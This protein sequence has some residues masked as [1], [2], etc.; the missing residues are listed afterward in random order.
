MSFTTE[1]RFV[2]EYQGG[3]TFQ[4]SGD[5]YVWVFVIDRLVMDLGGLHEVATGEFTLS[6]AAGTQGVATITREGP[7]GS[8]LTLD[9]PVT[10]QTGMQLGGVYEAVLFHA[11]RHE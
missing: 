9:D 7:P 5:D 1:T 4:F 8:A 10:V 3:E 2:F 6:A 11:E